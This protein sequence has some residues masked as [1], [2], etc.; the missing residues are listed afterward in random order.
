MP[1]DSCDAGR[2][3]FIIDHFRF[4]K[5]HFRFGRSSVNANNQKQQ[6]ELAANMNVNQK[7]VAEVV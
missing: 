5:D 4:G 2:K 1:T 3:S 6:V 7:Q